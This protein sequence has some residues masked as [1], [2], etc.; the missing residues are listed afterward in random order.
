M[1]KP[2]MMNYE[3]KVDSEELRDKILYWAEANISAPW[4]ISM[5][6]RGPD[7]DRKW[8]LFIDGGKASTKRK[9]TS[10]FRGKGFSI[11]QSGESWVTDTG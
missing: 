8:C 7:D 4:T 9:L 5:N 1:A 6:T 11:H 3:I 2:Q 10:A